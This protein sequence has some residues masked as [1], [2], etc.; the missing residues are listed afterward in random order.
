MTIIIYNLIPPKQVYFLPLGDKQ[1]MGYTNNNIK[2]YSYN[3]YLNDYLQTNCHK[4]TY[5]DKYLDEH[6][7]TSSLLL[8]LNNNYQ[9][10]N[11]NLSIIQSISKSSLITLWLGMQELSYHQDIDTYIIDE[12]INRIDKI[13]KF[14]RHYNNKEII[15][16]G[17]YYYKDAPSINEQIIKLAQKYNVTYISP[18]DI[19]NHPSFF[20]IPKSYELNYK[21]HSY[22]YKLI[23][24]ALNT[25]CNT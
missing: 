15:I 9:E 22:I 12:Y 10:K 13:L 5:N 20:F 25:T 19:T 7:T 21:G 16:I 24:R 18:D 4:V 23:K 3:D 2:G 6:E 8:K 17:L 11:T 14:I 1:A